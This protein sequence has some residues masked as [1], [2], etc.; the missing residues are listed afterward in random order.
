ESGAEELEVAIKEILSGGTYFSQKLLQNIVITKSNQTEKKIPEVTVKISQ[1]EQ[2]VLKLICSGC[3][4]TEI[5]EKLGISLRTVEGHRSNMINRTG[6][7]NSIQLVLYA[8]KNNLF[9]IN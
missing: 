3:S 7:K 2:E 4:N 1:R 5:A 9:M 8:Y 6:V